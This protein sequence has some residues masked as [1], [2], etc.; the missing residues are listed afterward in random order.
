MAQVFPS[1]LVHRDNPNLRLGIKSSLN[2][3]RQLIAAL[4]T[5]Y[6]SSSSPENI[7][8]SEEFNVE[9][10]ITVIR[11]S[12]E[13]KLSIAQN[14]PYIKIEEIEKTSLFKSQL[15]S[16]QVGIELFLH[17]GKIS[18]VDRNKQERT[19]SNRYNKCLSFSDKMIVIDTYLSAFQQKEVEKFLSSWL[20]GNDGDS[21]I[22]NGLKSILSTF[23]LDC[24]YKIKK[25]DNT[26][27]IFNIENIFQAL[28]EGDEVLF[29]DGETV[30]PL[31]VLNSYIDEGMLNEVE[32]KGGVYTLKNDTS[33]KL[34]R[35]TSMMS[36]SLD[37]ITRQLPYPQQLATN[38]IYNSN[39]ISEESTAIHFLSALRTKPFML[40][41]GIS[42]TGKSRNVR[43]LAQA[44]VT[45]KLQ[46][47]Y[48]PEYK[49]ENFEEDRWKLHKPANF[50]I[51]QVKP[52]WHNSMDVVGYLSNIPEPHYVFTPFVHFIV[53]AWQNPDV[54]FFLCLDEMNLAP[55][56]E[57]FAEYLSA[58]ESRSFENGEY[59]TDPIIK[60]FKEFGGKVC[61]KMLDELLPSFKASQTNGEE[62][63]LVGRLEQKGLT[64]PQ[65]LIVIGTVNMDETTFSFSRKV[66]DRAMSIEMNE[67]DYEK[68]ILGATDDDIK[69]LCSQIGTTELNSLLVKRHIEAEAVI[70][71][72][73][74]TMEG[75]DTL[76]VINYLESINKL[77]DGTPFKLG[78]RA[79]NEA[80]IYL[81]AAKDFGC[82]SN[83]AA[84]DDF[85]L[86][87][88]LSRIE[89][90][91]SKLKLTNSAFDQERLD[92]AG[93]NKDEA[94]KHGDL[95]LL[96]ALRE[97]IKN[98]LGEYQQTDAEEE[99]PQAEAETQ[100]SDAADDA[101][102]E[103]QTAKPVLLRSI[104]KI[105]SMISQ[106][107]RDHFVSYWN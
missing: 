70:T 89:G 8:Y 88:I 100:D 65:N 22:C 63:K 102:K 101:N 42:G 74:G 76:S 10:G 82:Q 26:E 43:K 96:T 95:T 5:I 61:E 3:F 16:L 105:D 32:K 94:E 1:P 64:L 80:L 35:H 73:G 99:E 7:N 2:S 62:G 78:Y 75:S 71:E 40:L 104:R 44:T 48:D 12:N 57:Y 103:V 106:L 49:G 97:I 107:E 27:I 81:A 58:I 92:S 30:G 25:S 29:K 85:T 13:I 54:P 84:M 19:G 28:S 20:K 83:S 38:K 98:H 36:T 9:S 91:E 51:I 87:K 60:P 55:V 86:M 53:K 68:F 45:E 6:K 11:L 46:G 39:D 33:E 50:E 37:L 69:N 18:F 67:V 47:E 41:A 52:N 31:R 17:L 77:L 79:S 56:E 23:I 14:F 34:V 59:E 93:V 15:E 72:L 66:L 4:Y 21:T 90:D 24:C